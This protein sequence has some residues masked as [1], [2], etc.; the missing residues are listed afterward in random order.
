MSN[1]RYHKRNI[2]GTK[3]KREIAKLE[4]RK[5][6]ISR[7]KIPASDRPDEVPDHFLTQNYQVTKHAVIRYIERVLEKSFNDIDKSKIRD[8]ANMIRKSLPKKIINHS[9]YPLVDNFYA[10]INNGLV[11][12]I[13]KV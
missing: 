5:K 1:N 2:Y 7:I 6:E 12:T 13:V 4:E 10:V 9:R 11:V 8:I 3:K